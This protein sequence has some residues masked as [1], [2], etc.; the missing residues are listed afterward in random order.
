MNKFYHK[1]LSK[2]L[3][4]KFYNILYLKKI[5]EI[6]ILDNY[7]LMHKFTVFYVVNKK[8]FKSYASYLNIT[9]V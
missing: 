8:V 4:L 9:R 1:L 6:K 5:K 2:N 3:K 7:C